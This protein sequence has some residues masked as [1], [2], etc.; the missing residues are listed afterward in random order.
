MSTASKLPARPSLEQLRKQ[1]K[2]K[3]QHLR[4][5]DPDAT[6]AVA[7]YALARDYGFESWPKLV[8]H[9]ESVASSG[10]LTLYEQ[11][12]SDMLA[13]YNG[14][15]AA[16]E[17]VGA[18]LGDSY[19]NQQR[20]ERLQDRINALQR[21]AAEPTLDDVRLVVARQFGFDTWEALGQSLAQP[22][23]TSD[24]SRSGLSTPP[25]Y[26]FDT[27][28]RVIQPQP[29]LTDADW[30]TIFAVME[31]RG[32]TGIST[33][34]IT[35]H[36]LDKLSRLDFVKKIDFSGARR[37]SDD[38]LLLLARMPQ[39]EELDLSG[40]HISITDRGLTVLRHLKN[41]KRFSMCWPQRITDS[42]VANLSFCDQ[43]EDVNLMGTPTGD[44]AINALRGKRNLRD[45]KTGKLVTD[46]SIPLL[47][48]FPVFKT[49]QGGEIA[50]D[51]MSF[52]G[53]PNNLMLDGPF[54]D[55]GLRGLAGLDGLFSLGFFWHARTF[56]SDGLAA[57]VDLRNLGHLGC[58]G[59]RCDDVA[60]R[61]I[62]TIPNLRMLMA[63]GTV[64]S[65][66]GFTAL[67]HSQTIE[68]IW[69]RECPNLASRGFT[70][71][72]AMPALKGLGVSCLHVDDAALANLPQF[73]A[74]TSLMPMDVTE[75][76]FRHV[77]KCEKL[78]KL[79]CM[80]CRDTGDAATAH[81]ADLKLEYYYAGKTRI[82]DR[83][84]EI[85]GRMQTLEKLEFWEIAGITDDGIAVL[86]GLP[87]LREI[88]V[89]GAPNVT[90]A[91]MSVFPASVRIS[92]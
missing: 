91:G 9:V 30:D 62:A 18:H 21:R 76:G 1:A 50:Y 26:R 79:W 60:M 22:V 17:R 59:E 48:D 82:T 61:H 3:L 85:L 33:S 41:L 87:R 23:D 86:A 32:I 5:S 47:H 63:Q 38:G 25:F 44:G 81:I 65:D 74:L 54:T 58:Q 78:E 16:L 55:G 19:N 84:L 70:A 80:Y 4:A 45:F 28:Q 46:A 31:E 75:D 92:Y 71:L 77:G 43:L 27:D 52:S 35:D 36:A 29:P 6:L 66:D 39:L 51:L 83:S 34:A 90:R 20:Q 40:W 89:E 67:S 10:R 42:G 68:Y 72:A 2:E 73:P 69:G 12:A 53:K 56:T 11:L 13:G 14:D 7:Q 64:A 57:L 49:W 24:V 88:S 37:L 15:N 8:H